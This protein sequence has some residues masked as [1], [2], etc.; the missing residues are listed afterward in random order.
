MCCL[1]ATMRRLEVARV[2]AVTAAVTA[3]DGGGD[4]GGGDG[5]VRR[6]DG[7]EGTVV[8]MGVVGGGGL[9]G[10]GDGGCTVVVK[11]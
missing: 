8:E 7:G 10:G 1:Q 9:G 4:G 11:A 5:A 6:R 3:G 2:V